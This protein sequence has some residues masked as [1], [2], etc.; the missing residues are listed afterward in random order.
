MTHGL[1]LCAA[2]LPARGPNI[3]SDAVS[4]ISGRTNQRGSAYRAVIGGLLS[5]RLCPHSRS[6]VRCLLWGPSHG[7]CE[8]DR[9]RLPNS[10]HG[11]ISVE[12]AAPSVSLA[13]CARLVST[14]CR[15]LA[16][17]NC[18]L[19]TRPSGTQSWLPRGATP[20]DRQD[21]KSTRL[22]SSHEWSSYAVFCLQK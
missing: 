10:N 20:W 2:A 14:A 4:V 7:T 18:Q 8:V 21:R 12:N 6:R 3:S 13:V 22:N 5:C 1:A 11:W 19:A 9:I 15:P 17:S 16:S